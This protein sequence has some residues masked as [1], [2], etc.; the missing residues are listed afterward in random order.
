[1]ARGAASDLVQ[2]PRPVMIRRSGSPHPLTVYVLPVCESID[3]VLT[4]LAGA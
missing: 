3:A 2:D 4:G 1:M